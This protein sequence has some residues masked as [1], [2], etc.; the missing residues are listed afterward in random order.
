MQAA[1]REN[2]GQA[3][4]AAEVTGEADLQMSDGNQKLS[5]MSASM[6]AILTSSGQIAK[7]IKAIE[8]IAFQTNILALNAAVER[9]APVRP[10]AASPWSPM[11]FAVWRSAARRPLRIPLSWIQE[12]V[13]VSDHRVAISSRKLRGRS[14]P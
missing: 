2:A 13:G 5:Q 3:R 10:A 1:I 14:T 8:E 6:D 4:H 9:P 12:S 11:R 7:I